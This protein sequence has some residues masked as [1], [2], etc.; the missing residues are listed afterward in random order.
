MKGWD[1]W[2]DGY[3]GLLFLLAEGGG[4]D[5]CVMFEPGTEG[6]GSGKIEGCGNLLDGLWGRPQ[7]PLG[8]EEQMAVN[9]VGS[10]TAGGLADT[11]SEAFLAETKL[12]GIVVDIMMSTSLLLDQL[13]ER[14]G[15]KLGGGE[16]V[17]VAL[18]IIVHTEK[19]SLHQQMH[20]MVA[21]GMVGNT[22]QS[23]HHIVEIDERFIYTWNGLN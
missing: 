5:S 21:M 16:L 20:D 7:L 3:W 13:K 22:Q 6:G 11:S 1:G 9:P 2:R 14:V 4:G 18:E 17:R 23:P 15:M 12:R 10:G 8:F 19:I